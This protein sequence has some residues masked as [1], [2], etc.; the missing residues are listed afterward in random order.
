MFEFFSARLN[1]RLSCV[2]IFNSHLFF[3]DDYYK[4]VAHISTLP[5]HD[6]RLTGDEFRRVA[7]KNRHEC[8][9]TFQATIEVFV[10]LFSSL[11]VLTSNRR[12]IYTSS[13]SMSLKYRRTFLSSLRCANN[14]FRILIL[15]GVHAKCRKT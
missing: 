5:G 9:D 12:L 15:Q 3:R 10:F 13:G 4:L 8:H 2:G 11:C 14:S 1:T 7:A 6:R